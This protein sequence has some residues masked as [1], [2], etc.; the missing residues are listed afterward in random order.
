VR[1]DRRH[2]LRL[3]LR[4]AG[5]AAAS[6]IGARLALAQGYIAQVYPSRPVHI[7]VGY[8]AGGP[9]DIAARLIAHWLSER[10][11]RQF[12]VENRPGGGSNLATEAVAR[13]APDGHTLL[14][15]G[16][17]A[18]INASLYDNLS[19]NFIRDIVPVATMFQ[20]P[21]VMVVGPSFPAHTVPEFLAY[22]KAHPGKLNMAS[23]GNGSPA[24][25]LGELFKMMAG[26]D[27]IHVPYR[28]EAGALP[29]LLAGQV[30]VMFPAASAVVEHVRQGK[31]R[32]LAVTTAA[33]SPFLPQVPAV[34][35]YVAG[36]EASAWYGLGAP[37][38]TPADIVAKLNA[39]INAALA[40]ARLK[41]RIADLGGTPF[42]TSPSE[43][44]AL[45]AEE[46]ERWAK[47]VKFAGIKAD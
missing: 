6:P 37:R 25:V 10:L 34:A 14:L 3:G 11:G 15:V 47:V 21:L 28:G 23:G 27:M 38:G 43:F 29:D 17:S 8:A 22:A 9:T 5:G 16:A 39:E 12:V 18:A 30:Q 4:L 26:V 2:F 42:A 36:Y 24:H 19:F 20:A 7:L 40:D 31:L 32:A 41:D 33:R 35:E 1:L 13:A 45:I 44:S 46:T